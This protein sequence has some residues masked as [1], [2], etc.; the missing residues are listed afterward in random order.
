[1][2]QR[3]Q[4]CVS[5]PW[6]V[7][8]SSESSKTANWVCHMRLLATAPCRAISGRTLGANSP[9]ST[10]N[11][12]W[13]TTVALVHLAI[14]NPGTF[15]LEILLRDW[16]KSVI[17]GTVPVLVMH[18]YMIQQPRASLVGCS[19][20]RSELTTLRLKPVHCWL[21][22]TFDLMNRQFVAILAFKPS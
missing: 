10:D 17:T 21:V 14:M 2:W 20:I 4:Q 11:V 12:G 15:P 22:I 16:H 7:L 6:K 1:M 19:R 9:V 5:H 13:V 8:T 3:L 18:C